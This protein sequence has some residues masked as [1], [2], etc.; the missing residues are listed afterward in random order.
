MKRTL[1][2]LTT[3]AVLSISAAVPM[4]SAQGMTQV[5]NN[6]T[7]MIYNDLSSMQMDTAM[8]SDLSLGDINQIALIMGSSDSEGE[9]K[10]KIDAILRSAAGS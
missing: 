6:L 7:G 2:A 8:I 1:S 10:A 3:A 4:A 9:K 5:L